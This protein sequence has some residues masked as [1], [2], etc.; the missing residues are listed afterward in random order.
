MKIRKIMKHLKLF[1]SYE[2][3]QKYHQQVVLNVFQ[4]IIDDYG[5]DRY[6]QGETLVGTGYGYM[7]TNSRENNRNGVSITMFYVIDGDVKDIKSGE[8]IRN[9]VNTIMNR[10]DKMGYITEIVDGLWF[11]VEVDYSNLI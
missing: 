9:K 4:D 6:A 10:L 8:L 1:E 5:F 2:G 7:I 11:Y 3:D